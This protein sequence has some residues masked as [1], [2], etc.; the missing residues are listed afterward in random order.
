MV[1]LEENHYYYY[2]YED[3]YELYGNKNGSTRGSI[4]I[5]FYPFSFI[6]PRATCLDYTIRISYIA[7]R[8]LKLSSS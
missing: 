5:A 6:T 7:V 2:Y 1:V 4:S 8:W 3:N